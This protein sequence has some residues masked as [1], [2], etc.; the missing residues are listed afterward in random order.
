MSKKPKIRW[1]NSDAQSLQNAI[2]EFNEKRDK[3]TGEIPALEG[4]MPDRLSIDKFLPEIKTRKDYNR[5]L[6]HIEAFNENG[7][8]QIIDLDSGFKRTKWEVEN[9]Q[10][11]VNT[12]NALRT[13]E[14]KKVEKLDATSRGKPLGMKRGEMGS[15]RLNE[16]NLK[17]FNPAKIGSKKAWDKY[18]EGVQ[19]QVSSLYRDERLKTMQ[20]NYIKT[21]HNHFG[22]YGDL[23]G[24]AVEALSPEEFERI[25]MQDQEATFETVANIFNPKDSKE[26][27]KAIGEVWGVDMSAMVDADFDEGEISYGDTN[28]SGH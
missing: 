24:D 7:A 25:Y 14:R 23:I 26:K 4:I 21:L 1:S 27:L 8:E 13:K 11:D 3:I 12:I 17:N 18:T 5:I 22:A 2:N 16:Y 6:H 19:R 10:Q 28:W 20:D 15:L 9:T